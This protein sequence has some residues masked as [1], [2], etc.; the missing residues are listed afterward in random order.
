MAEVCKICGSNQ[1]SAQ[2]TCEDFTVSHEK[3]TLVQ[4]ESCGFWYTTLPPDP[5]HAGQY[6]KSESYVS[7]SDTKKGLINKMY[8]VFRSRAANRKYKLIREGKA[9]IRLLDY[10]CGTGYFLSR[11]KE[12]RVAVLGVE[13]DDGARKVAQER[14]LDVLSLE[15]F[16][17]S[18]AHV[19]VIT[20]WHVLE[21]VYDLHET[22]KRLL[23]V[24]DKEGSVFIAVPNRES[25]DAKIYKELWA[26]YDVPR[27][28]YHFR[29]EDM[30]RLAEIHDLK[31]VDVRPMKLDS[32]Y[33]SM[34]SERYAGGNMLRAIWRGWLSNRKGGKTNSSSLIYHLKRK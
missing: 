22:L 16:D 26:A 5:D 29:K 14:G 1:S 27:H 15:E 30:I 31:V 23:N 11:C 9:D 21:H 34:L 18:N 12:K 10:G 17:T 2:L 25:Y 7:H 13:P 32:Y 20:L 4:C 33:V 6:Y 3:F 8:H 28:L 19:N 24:L